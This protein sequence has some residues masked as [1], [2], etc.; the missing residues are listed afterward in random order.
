M[1][2]K[3][4]SFVFWTPRII[5]IIF[6]LFMVLM[7]LDV[8]DGNVGFWKTLLG[9]F[10]HNI[11]AIILSLLLILSWRDGFL[12][13]IGFFTFGIL[14]IILILSNIFSTGF[15]AIYLSW[16]LTISGFAFLIGFLFLIG[17]RNKKQF[18]FLKK[19]QK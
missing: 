19:N 18:K 9:F 8:F 11:P 12:A 10:I 13:S 2:E 16:I 5:S 14:Y 17:K 6:I 3:T 1:G 7:S 4:N 15:R